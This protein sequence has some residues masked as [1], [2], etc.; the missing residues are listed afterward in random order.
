[1]SAVRTVLHL[2]DTG[3]PGGAETVVLDLVDG[4]D[5]GRWRSVVALPIRDWMH[6]QL[7]ARGHEPVLLPSDG[8]LN[9]RYLAGIVR[10]VRRHRVDLVHAHLFGSAVYGRLAGLLCG[11]PV[12]ATLHGE[13]DIAPDER[14]RAA[15]LRLLNGCRSVVLVSERLRDSFVEKGYVRP[16]RSRVIANGVDTERYRPRPRRGLRAE[17]GVP[18]DAF[19]VGA[20]GNL[21]PAKGYEVLLQAAALLKARGAPCRCVVVGQLQ[22]PLHGQLLALRTALGVEDEVRFLGFRD[23]VEEVLPEFDVYA[24]TSHSEGLPLSTLQAMATGLPVVA[25]RCGGPEQIVVPG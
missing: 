5:P 10:T 13:G 1:M 22:E 25:T 15:K 24:I 20:V 4:L 17:L 2:I 7:T 16:E 9:L 14:F 19:L 11:V 12:V 8:S 21:R 3:G 18:D 23:D 6:G